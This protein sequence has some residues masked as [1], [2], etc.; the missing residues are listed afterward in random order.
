MIF[1]KYLN[2]TGHTDVSLISQDHTMEDIFIIGNGPSLN[3]FNARDFKNVFTIGTNRSWLWGDTNILIW[4]DSR[5]TDEI[6]FFKLEKKDYSKWICSR[7]KAF[8]SV[9]LKD[10]SH[11]S[12][13][14]DYTFAD[15]WMKD[16]LDTNIRWNG[17]AFHA[18]ALAK[19]ISED[20]KIHLVGIDLDY[21]LDHHFFNMING[22]NQGYYRSSWEQTNYNYKKRLDMMYSNFK[23]LKDRGYSFINHS[24]SSRLC[25]LFGYK[26]F[27]S[28]T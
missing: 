28:E 12:K 5:I 2:K 14:L 3:R 8:T 13:M 27:N 9:L 1:R 15:N 18:I 22:F 19:F 11:V 20:A 26:E 23:E 24:E 21:E 4:R 10:H 7:D 25:E 16:V 17:I 6:E